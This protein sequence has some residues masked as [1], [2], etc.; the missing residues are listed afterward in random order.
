MLEDF[1]RTIAMMARV[2]VH[3]ATDRPRELA[4]GVALGAGG[5]VCFGFIAN[6]LRRYS[7]STTQ[8]PFRDLSPG[9]EAA[10]PVPRALEVLRE[11]AGRM[12]LVAAISFVLLG[13]GVLAALK[14]HFN[15]GRPAVPHWS[16]VGYFAIVTFLGVGLLLSL[17]D[18]A[19]RWAGWLRFVNCDRVE[20]R[21]TIR[22]LGERTWESGEGLET[23]VALRY[24]YKALTPEGREGRFVAEESIGE[25][26]GRRL[27]GVAEIP[28]AYDRAHPDRVRRG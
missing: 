9:E 18:L 13:F 17:L 12:L 16:T 27:Q 4:L 22:Y 20:T 23:W 8:P 14:I 15:H 21:A 25:G 7:I 3:L 5:L 19:Q 26:E 10:A 11:S 28:V 1:S 2:L 6:F 24:A